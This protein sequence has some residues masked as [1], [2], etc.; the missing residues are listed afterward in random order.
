MTGSGA[1][2][3]G[4]DYQRRSRDNLRYYLHQAIRAH[5]QLFLQRQHRRGLSIDGPL[6]CG[7][8]DTES[9]NAAMLVT[10]SGKAT[11]GN[12]ILVAI[13]NRTQRVTVPRSGEWSTRWTLSIGAYST[14][15]TEQSGATS[16][17]VLTRKLLPSFSSQPG[18]LI[19]EVSRLV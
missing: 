17:N 16:V 14:Q 4:N 12:A 8:C 3:S 1:D 10:I 7:T 9:I 19:I 6:E 2:R 11:P 15:V 13:G 5:L 18:T